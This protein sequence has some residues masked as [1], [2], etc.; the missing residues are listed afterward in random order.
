MP[1]QLELVTPAPDENGVRNTIAEYLIYHHWLVIRINSGVAKPER[2]DGSRGFVP[3]NYWQVLGDDQQTTGASDLFALKDSLFMAIE[4]KRPGNTPTLIQ[5]KFMDEVR[6]RGGLA[7]AAD[8]IEDVQQAL[9]GR[10]G[11]G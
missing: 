1:K 6:K 4:C 3:F 7:F 5:E 10:R 9:E 2:E 11:V 8:C